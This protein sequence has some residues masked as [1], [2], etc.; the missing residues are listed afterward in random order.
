MA[1]GGRF[2]EMTLAQRQEAQARE[3]EKGANGKGED[4]GKGQS[5]G[6]TKGKDKDT[7]KGKEK[8]SQQGGKGR[9]FEQ[10]EKRGVSDEM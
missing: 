10:E 3:Q 1:R 7:S 2:K 8:G 5:K 4:K 9:H 6:Q